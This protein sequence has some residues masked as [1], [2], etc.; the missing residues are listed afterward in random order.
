MKLKDITGNRFGRLIAVRATNKRKH[1]KVIW[2]CE[3]D[4]GNYVEV[5]RGSLSS[6][7]TKSCGCYDFERRKSNKYAKNLKSGEASF[8]GLLYDYRRRAKSKGYSFEL[9]KE[10][11]R[12]LTSGNCYYCGVKPKQVNHPKPCVGAYIYNGI[13]RVDTTKGYILNNCVPC[14]IQC[15]SDKNS[16]KVGIMIKTLEFLGHKV[17]LNWKGG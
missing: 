11:F 17:I 2:L 1:M 16:C 14:C 3:C 10:Q 6:G 8:N 13:D 9:T 15:N 4:C 12:E 7:N 5:V